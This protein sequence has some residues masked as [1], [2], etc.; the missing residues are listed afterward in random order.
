M[1]KEDSLERKKENRRKNTVSKDTCS[2]FTEQ[3]YFLLCLTFLNY[4]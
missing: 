2:I 1:I 3:Q 4:V